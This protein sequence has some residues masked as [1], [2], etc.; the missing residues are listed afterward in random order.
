MRRGKTFFIISVIMFACFFSWFIMRESKGNDSF[1]DSEAYVSLTNTVEE[2]ISY[3]R[4]I[5]ITQSIDEKNVIDADVTSPV[6]DVCSSFEI[7]PIEISTEMGALLFFPEDSTSRTI[8]EIDDITS[9]KTDG[10]NRFTTQRGICSFRKEGEEG[11]K[12]DEIQNLLWRYSKEFPESVNRSLDFMTQDEAIKLAINIFSELGTCFTPVLEDC[13][14][15]DHQQLMEYQKTLFSSDSI[16]DEFGKTYLLDGLSEN[17]DAYLLSF[18]FTY[19]DIPIYG[20][21]GEPKVR[22]VENIYPPFQSTATMVISRQGLV[23]FQAIGIYKEISEQTETQILNVDEL[24]EVYKQKCDLTLWNENRRVSNIYLEYIPILRETG[25]VLTPYWCLLIDLETSSS[26]TDEPK[27]INAIESERFNA[28]TGKD[29][30][31][32]G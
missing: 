17:Y 23:S 9:L 3:E 2:T 12:Y 7:E 28:F 1:A 15:L 6:G 24:L 16:Y 11:K 14:A 19:R 26:P 30:L 32:G 29:I 25:M 31:Y 22:F 5:H 21:E 10:G 8:E 13:I 20:F 18:A 4:E 27:W